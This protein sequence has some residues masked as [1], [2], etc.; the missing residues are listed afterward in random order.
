MVVVVVVITQFSRTF[1][2]GYKLNGRTR[3][4]ARITVQDRLTR[5][6]GRYSWAAGGG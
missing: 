6:R 1:V 3:M 5:E 4:F 2:N